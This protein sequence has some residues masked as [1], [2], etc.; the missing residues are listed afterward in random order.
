AP[1]PSQRVSGMKPPSASRP[2]PLDELLARADQ[3]A[4]CIAAQ[5]AERQASSEYAARMEL[6]AQ[7]QAEAGQQAQARDDVELERLRRSFG[8]H[9]DET[10]HQMSIRATACASLPH[11]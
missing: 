3:A 5:Q 4:Q 2:E 7:A 1:R 10:V 6:E 8:P 9:P 11:A